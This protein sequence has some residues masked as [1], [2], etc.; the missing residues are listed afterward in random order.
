MA[1]FFVQMIN[2]NIQTSTFTHV[3]RL[4]KKFGKS[5]LVF[6]EVPLK[7]KSGVSNKENQ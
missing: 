3:C 6:L 1:S 7:N 4:L 5:H 2:I